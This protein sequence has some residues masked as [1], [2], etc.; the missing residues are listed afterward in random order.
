[1][2]SYWAKP[3]DGARA[4]AVPQ[5]PPG[6]RGRRAPRAASSGWAPLPM[7]APALAVRELERCVRTLGFAG[8][9]IGSHVNDW[10][11]ERPGPVRGLRGRRRAGRGGVR[12]SL[13]HDGRGADAEVLAAVA[14]RDAGGDVAGHLLGDLRRRARAAA[15]LRI[16]FAHGGGAFP[17]TLGRIE[18]GFL[19]APRSLCRRQPR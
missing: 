14:G 2:F 5:R 12:A 9:Q 7:Q 10:N 1:M 17:G 15:A 4:C 8:V 16:C 13:G 18:H 11:L 19:D 6:R 3:E